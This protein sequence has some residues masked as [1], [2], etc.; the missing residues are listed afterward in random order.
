MTLLNPKKV[1]AAKV[2]IES[3]NEILAES[4]LYSLIILQQ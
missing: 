1:I 4:Y 3:K 2:G